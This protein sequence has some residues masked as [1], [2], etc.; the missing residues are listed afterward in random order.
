MSKMMKRLSIAALLAGAIGSGTANAALFSFSR[1]TNNGAQNLASQFLIDVQSVNATTVNFIV[2][3]TGPLASSIA[4]VYFDD[5]LNSL[6]NDLVSLAP[7]AGVNFSEGGSP[8]NLPGGNPVNFD[9]DFRATSNGPIINGINPNES[10]GIRFSLFNGVTFANVISAMNN[11]DLRLGIHVQA[12]PDG[13]SDSFITTEP[14]PS[15]TASML[16]LVGLALAGVM[17]RR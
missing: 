5:R 16:G 14:I 10:L 7:S 15:P 6:L 13:Q 1:I 17:R 4:A 8:P 2:S 3:N 12:L 9:D 11:G